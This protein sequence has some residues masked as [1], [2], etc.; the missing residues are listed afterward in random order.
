MKTLANILS[1]ALLV[2]SACV[3]VEVD[4]TTAVTA[5][6]E[7]GSVEP[8]PEPDSFGP[9]WQPTTGEASST[10]APSNEDS[11]GVEETTGTGSDSSTSTGLPLDVPCNFSHPCAEGVCAPTGECVAACQADGR[12]AQDELCLAGACLDV[13]ADMQE[14]QEIAFN[15]SPLGTIQAGDID[16]WN[17]QLPHPGQFGVSVKGSPMTAYLLSGDTILASPD[18]AMA[19]GEEIVQYHAL[20]DNAALPL[21]V[22]LMSN[23]AEPVDY[24]FW[25]IDLTP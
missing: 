16:V 17:V 6:E 8:E 25:T 23:S 19:V 18:D 12:C 9:D 10:S 2:L 4:A 20:V 22:L 13:G 15:E 5:A 11:T 3:V 14:A 21:T 1:V 24:Y 7:A